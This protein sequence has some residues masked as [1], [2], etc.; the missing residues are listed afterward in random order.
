MDLVEDMKHGL[1]SAVYNGGSN[2]S[3][4]QKQLFCLARAILRKNKILIIDE[5]TANVD[6]K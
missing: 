5:A 1:D 2:L 3:V 6:F 4:G